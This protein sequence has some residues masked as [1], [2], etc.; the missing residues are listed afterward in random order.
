MR[1]DAHMNTLTHTS[2]LPLFLVLWHL[3]INFVTSVAFWFDKQAAKRHVR[4]IPK[5]RF[6]ALALLGG[7]PSALASIH[8][9]RH[10]TR[11]THFLFFQG[12]AAVVHM[13]LLA[14]L[15]RWILWG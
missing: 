4:R 13:A 11:K 9:F 5:M 3:V 8:L 10:K 6:H 14:L 12:I 7:W 1:I 15:A 2:D